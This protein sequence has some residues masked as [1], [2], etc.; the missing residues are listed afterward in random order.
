MNVRAVVEI[1][2]K[3]L[4]EEQHVLANFPDAIWVTFSEGRTKFYVPYA[5]YEAIMKMVTTWEMAN[6]K[7]Q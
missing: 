6:R 4:E 3:T 7:E 2:T 5:Q 1:E